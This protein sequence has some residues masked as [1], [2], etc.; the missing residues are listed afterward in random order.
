MKN[1]KAL[2]TSAL[3]KLSPTRAKLT[4]TIAGEKL[5]AAFEESIQHLGEKLELPGFRP[6]KAPRALILERLGYAPV[7]QHALEHV[8]PA[9]YYS[10]VKEHKFEPVEPPAISI[11]Q[12]GDFSRGREPLVFT[13]E[14]DVLPEIKI[15]GWKTIKLPKQSKVEVGEQ[16]LED[17]LGFVRNQRATHREVTRPAQN[18]D[19]V[20]LSF[21]GSIDDV[22][23]EALQSKHYPVVLGSNVLVPGFEARIEGMRKGEE[24]EFELTFPKDY[25]RAEFADKKAQFTVSLERVEEV[26]APPLD[27]TLAQSLGAKTVT[28]LQEKLRTRLQQEKALFQRQKQVDTLLEALAGKIQSGVPESLIR[29]EVQR[30]QERLTQHL[31]GQ[32]R[33]LQDYLKLIA[34]TSE[35]HERELRTQ[36]EKTAKIS[37]ALRRVSEDEKL[38]LKT[39]EDA[40]K[41]IEHILKH[42]RTA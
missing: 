27:D 4:V 23:H 33:S 18:G 42:V 20:E 9:A 6:G 29:R 21:T 13:A 34:K 28:E 2:W 7:G 11:T 36:A 35:E 12:H 15:S 17:A 10:A 39:E 24:K 37:L 16:E 3:T 32:Q 14:V 26:K 40:Q 25:P 41:V 1:H 38:P 22:P 19:R 30:L 8:I 5:V 31:L